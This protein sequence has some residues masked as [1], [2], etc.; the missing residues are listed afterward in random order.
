MAKRS[1]LDL[2]LAERGTFTSRTA[3]AKAIRAGQVKLGK[4]G[5]IAL[6]PSQEVTP[7]QEIEVLGGQKYV[8]R[9]GIKLENGLDTLGVDPAGKLCLDVGASTGGFTDCLLQRGAK[10]VIALDV[11][12][13]QID[14]GMRSRSDVTV[15]ERLNARDLLPMD[16]EYRPE[17]A[18]IDVSFISLVKVLPAVVNVMADEAVILAMVKPQFELGRARVGRGGVVRGQEDRREAVA[19]VADFA[20]ELGLSLDGIAP[21]GLPGPKGNLE[22]FIQLGRHSGGGEGEGPPGPRRGADS[23]AA[24]CEGVNL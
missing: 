13:G 24:L 12:Y 14:A 5:P 23:G 2:L 4:D 22:T 15:I 19:G 10:H 6:R 9:G 1:R 8:S 21:T 20:L 18:V 3:A 16:L 7:D 17:L 11:A